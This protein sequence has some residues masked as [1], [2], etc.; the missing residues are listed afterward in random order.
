MVFDKESYAVF[1]SNSS[2]HPVRIAADGDLSND[3]G[4][5]VDYSGNVGIGTVG[6]GAKLEVAG[7]IKAT[8]LAISGPLSFPGNELV[9]AGIPVARTAPEDADLETVLVDRKTGKLYLQ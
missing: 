1:G 7:T 8:G 4:I 3:K 6:P 9:L 2:A 5:T